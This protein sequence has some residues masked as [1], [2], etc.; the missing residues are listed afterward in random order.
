MEWIV[1]FVMATNEKIS[2]LLRINRAMLLRLRLSRSGISD[3]ALF[4][5]SMCGRTMKRLPSHTSTPSFEVILV[6]FRIRCSAGAFANSMIQKC[7]LSRR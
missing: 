4:L 3:R 5:T 2:R 1:T 7:H 6:E